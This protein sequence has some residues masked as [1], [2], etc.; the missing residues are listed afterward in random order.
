ML[1]L[2]TVPCA[3]ASAQHPEIAV[4]RAKAGAESSHLVT[5]E[6]KEKLGIPEA[7]P[8]KIAKMCKMEPISFAVWCECCG[9]ARRGDFTKS[10][11][12]P[13]LLCQNPGARS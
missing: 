8:F 4:A 2:D 3:L 9:K 11:C 7:G 12:L 10:A 6:A 13:C 5:M 1:V